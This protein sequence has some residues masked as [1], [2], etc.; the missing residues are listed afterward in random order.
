MLTEML[1]AAWH[2]FADG[3]LMNRQPVDSSA[4]DN[5]KLDTTSQWHRKTESATQQ[6]A[7]FQ[8]AWATAALVR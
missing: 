8:K 7:P 6:A 3:A 1:A 4:S 5:T 2:T